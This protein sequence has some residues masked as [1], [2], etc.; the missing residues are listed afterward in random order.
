MAKA[1]LV[2]QTGATY[3]QLDFW[4][5]AGYLHPERPKGLGSGRARVWPDDELAVATDMAMLVFY[6]FTPR[7]AHAIARA[8]ATASVLDAVLAALAST[9]PL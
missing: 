3:R 2:A 5:R 4:T 9:A 7:L 8:G 1:D 6:G